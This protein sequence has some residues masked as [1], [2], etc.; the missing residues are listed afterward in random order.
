MGMPLI[1]ATC[2]PPVLARLEK[3]SK[4]FTPGK[5]PSW[6]EMFDALERKYGKGKVPCNTYD[7][8]RQQYFKEYVAPWR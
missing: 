6:F 7:S 5:T 2:N 4:Q 1:V 3:F 8:A